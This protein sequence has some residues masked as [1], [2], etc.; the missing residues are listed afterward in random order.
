MRYI[1]F[2]YS[3]TS[4]YVTLRFTFYPFTSF[5][6]RGASKEFVT[7]ESGTRGKEC[8]GKSETKTDGE[9]AVVFG[10]VVISSYKCDAIEKE[11]THCI[12]TLNGIP[13]MHVSKLSSR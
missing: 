3:V 10:G 12:V 5:L 8:T 11:Y 2:C 13:V 9:C 1:A 6:G 7:Q 4:R